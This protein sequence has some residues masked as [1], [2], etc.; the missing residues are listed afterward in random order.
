MQIVTIGDNLHKCQNLFSGENKRKKKKKK[1]KKKKTTYLSSA[2]LAERVSEVNKAC[3]YRILYF[4][5]NVFPYF[6]CW[7][8]K[9]KV[10]ILCL[11]VR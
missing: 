10:S 9:E 2:E 8:L 11:C 3:I 7:S 1:K 4:T 5:Y 6:C